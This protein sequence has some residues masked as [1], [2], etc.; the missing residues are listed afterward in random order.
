M[1]SS[2]KVDLKKKLLYYVVGNSSLQPV[3]SGLSIHSNES[4]ASPRSNHHDEYAS[5]LLGDEDHA[6]EA[7]RVSSSSV[8][9][10]EYRF[11]PGNTCLDPALPF[12]LD[13][14]HMAPETFNNTPSAYQSFELHDPG[15]SS[16]TSLSHAA[17]QDTIYGPLEQSGLYTN[18][19]GTVWPPAEQ[20]LWPVSEPQGPWEHALNYEVATTAT[21]S[22]PRVSVVRALA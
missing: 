2:M 20:C 11:Q 4:N 19:G 9:Q 6:A 12:W 16:S 14:D 22:D 3:E 17:P 15:A 1:L 7:T 8:S 13:Q 10:S 21:G 5:A 18:D